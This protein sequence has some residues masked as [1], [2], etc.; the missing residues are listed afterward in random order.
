MMLV[1]RVSAVCCLISYEVDVFGDARRMSMLC[2]VEKSSRTRDR[3]TSAL[4]RYRHLDGLNPSDA[5]LGHVVSIVHR[6][7]AP[8]PLPS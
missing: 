4:Q 7:L 3:R 5:G 8:L 1:A 6:S 2:L